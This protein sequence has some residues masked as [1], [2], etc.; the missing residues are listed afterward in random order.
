MDDDDL[1]MPLEAL[2]LGV[3]GGASTLHGDIDSLRRVK[4]P[5]LGN[6]EQNGAGAASGVC[7]AGPGD[8][9]VPI[10][11]MQPDTTATRLL[12]FQAL[13]RC[14]AIRLEAIAAFFGRTTRTLLRWRLEQGLL[15]RRDLRRLAPGAQRRLRLLEE[16][17]PISP[18][19]A[20]LLALGR[21]REACRRPGRR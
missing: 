10:G 21:A 3:S 18:G 20:A 9:G 16:A 13:W 15:H 11:K 7:C 12:D 17:L 2:R 19:A 4:G 6:L 8:P 14:P 1:P 5:S